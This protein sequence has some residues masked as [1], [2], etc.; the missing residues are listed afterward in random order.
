MRINETWI[1]DFVLLHAVNKWNELPY[2]LKN[3]CIKYHVLFYVDKKLT[4]F[5]QMLYQM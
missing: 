5:Y 3:Y 1:K 4:I 2:N